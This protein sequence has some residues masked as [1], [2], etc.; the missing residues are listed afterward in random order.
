M[1]ELFFAENPTALM[2]LALVAGFLCFVFGRKSK[3]RV[4]WNRLRSYVFRT[5]T[6]LLLL[7]AIAGPYTEEPGNR[8]LLPVYVDIS[9]SLD[10]SLAQST[11]EAAASAA[12][13]NDIV[14]TF[15]FAENTS[16]GDTRSSTPRYTRLKDAGTGLNI[17]KSSLETALRHAL[18]NN[19][20][21]V[22]LLS[23]GYE[24]AGS[25]NAAIPLLQQN[26]IKVYPFIPEQFSAAEKSIRLLD[27]R[28]PLIAKKAQV[29][30]SSISIK[31]SLQAE[32]SGTLV[33]TVDGEV[34]FEEEIRIPGNEERRIAVPLSTLGEG[35]K[36]VVATFNPA[37]AAFPPSSARTFISGE[38]REKVLLLSGATEDGQYLET[39]LTDQQF[40]LVHQKAGA[41]DTKALE[42]LSA[43]SVIMLNNIALKELPSS[44]P[45]KVKKYVTNGGGFIMI[46][47]NNSYGLG[48]YKDTSIA[49]I[50][51]VHIVPPQKEKKRLN[52]AVQLVLDKSGSMKDNSKMLFSK[53]AAVQVVDSLKPDDYLGIIGFDSTPFELLPIAP[54]GT[55]RDKAK[56]RVQ[57]MFPGT[58]T[59]L[60]PA[61]DLGRRRLEFAKA[62]RK[63]MIILTDG[64]I[65]DGPA[66]RPHYLQLVDEMRRTG[67]TVSTFMIGGEQ[68]F[69][70]REMADVGGGAFYRTRNVSN[71]PR[72]FLDDIKVSTGERTQK[73][74]ER[75]DV[76]K[77]DGRIVSTSLSAFPIL[78]G[79]VQTKRRE[80][81]NL[82]LVAYANRK[83]EPL[84][85]SWKVGKGRSLA[86]TSDASGR[87]SYYWVGWPRFHTFWS[88]LI[89]TAKGSAAANETIQFEL[90]H[91][92]KGGSLFIE[93]TVFS[94]ALPGAL[95]MKVESS[96]G[97]S[98][99][100]PLK[101]LALGH[102][103]TRVDNITAGTYTATLV[104]GEKELTPAV[105]ALSGELFGEQKGQGYNV[106]LLTKLAEATGGRV[107]PKREE[108][109]SLQE[110]EVI[111]KPLD[112]F[113]LLLALIL[114]LVEIFMREV[115]LRLD[116]RKRWLKLK[117]AKVKR[118]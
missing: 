94:S 38:K 73:E 100:Y 44:F 118:A 47:G 32:S 95:Q 83:A 114:F 19:E 33:V 99:L 107:N 71:L 36:E 9:D 102:Y 81:A 113:F 65:P 70:L 10:E 41:L 108:L 28:A 2:A 22:L 35:I 68:D 56:K 63:H 117:F 37:A 48:G 91:Y 61:L 82:E 103:R 16:D 14:R 75:F 52:I 96:D 13:T 18:Q 50:L 43:Y 69:I 98:S 87:W 97:N 106:A 24:T 111:R 21:T 11:L 66:R 86:Y 8:S 76:R 62:G 51:P 31:N 15:S 5:L 55:N 53:M 116:A 109:E 89:D 39:S 12:S 88:E 20:K 74:A 93:T 110:F 59:K 27:I 60:L 72:L 57:L 46:G 84:L 80:K 54:V 3:S 78:R 90:N 26:G 40:Q 45:S 58:T 92:V 101:A 104:A 29:V 34:S 115:G 49:D 1:S 7:A 25:I 6:L 23:D 4:G 112:T 105:L 30:Q 64:K 85:A 42:K 67:I 77:G 17:G 79:Y